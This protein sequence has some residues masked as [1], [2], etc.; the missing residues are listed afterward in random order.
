LG[1]NPQIYRRYKEKQMSFRQ[2]I[3]G[4]RYDW[5]KT[6]N[7]EQPYHHQYHQTLVDKIFLCM[8]SDPGTG[9]PVRVSCNFSQAL[10]RIQKIDNMTRGIPKIMYLVGWQ[11]EGHDSKY[12]AWSEVN[13]HLK[14][15][16]DKTPL[17]S[18][19][20]LMEEGYKYNTTVSLHINMNDAYE[21]SPFWNI[22]KEKGTIIRKGGVWGGEQCYLISHVKEWEA[23]LAQKRIDDLVEML[24]L[25]KAGTIHV[26]A[27]WMVD[28]DREAELS[29][30]RKIIRYWRSKGID[31]TTEGI[32]HP[33]LDNGFFGLV[34]MVWHINNAGWKR[35]NEFTE[36]AYMAMPASLFCGGADHSQR[37][38]LFGTNM[39]GEGIPNSRINQYLP[40]FCLKTLPWQYLNHYHR[41]KLINDS[42][43]EVQFSDGLIS[44]VA[45]GKPFIR[46]NDVIIRDG[47]DLFIP[48]LWKDKEIIAFS[49]QGYHKR[50]WK[51]PSSWHKSGKISLHEITGDG[52]KFL[53]EIPIVGDTVELS[54]ESNQAC[55]LIPV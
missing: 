43:K 49:A 47:N 44:R 34:P 29:A 17:D 32:V 37:A 22:F 23:G 26:D 15:P 3:S 30:M 50:S 41:N 46:H 2:E 33:D 42:V 20:W 5:R 28:E 19:L 40:Q 38:L 1:Y 52:L 31:F 18:L 9:S 16:E 11:F 27:F 6:R 13:H 39:I 24:P 35:E 21:N 45:E 25:K 4:E 54:L 48:A 12:P 8:K 10:E 55:S 53:Q 7:P 51:L 14:R 36:E